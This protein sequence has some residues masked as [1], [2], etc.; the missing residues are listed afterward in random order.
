MSISTACFVF[1]CTPTACFIFV[2]I[3]AARHRA[4]LVVRGGAVD[5]GRLF[6]EPGASMGSSLLGGNCTGDTAA[7]PQ[8]VAAG[9]L[10][11]GK[12]DGGRVRAAGG[13]RGRPGCRP[14]PSQRALLQVWK[15]KSCTTSIFWLTSGRDHGSKKGYLGWG[16]CLLPPPSPRKHAS[17]W[18]AS[19]ELWAGVCGLY[20]GVDCCVGLLSC[21]G[22]GERGQAR[23]QFASAPAGRA[24]RQ[25]RGN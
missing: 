6:E 21:G 10:C 23:A 22:L 12:D 1:V 3:S 18:M 20:F 4:E 5:T 11:T 17:W 9:T 14:H 15:P 7:V 2:C 24:L 13:S 25:C 8:D 19:F 16:C